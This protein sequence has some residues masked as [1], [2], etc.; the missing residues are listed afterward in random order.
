[1]EQ[2]IEKVR[3]AFGERMVF[4]GL[5]GS[6][7][8][9]EATEH[10]DIDVVVV[11]DTFT[12][13]DLTVYD[14]AISA[15]PHREKI[16]G[17]ISGVAEL[18]NWDRA[19]RFQFYY[20]TVSFYGSLDAIF[21]APDRAD[22]DH[23]VHAGA[24]AIYHGCVH[25]A[26]HEKSPEIL[27]SLYKSAVFVLQA[28]YFCE[29]EHYLRKKTDLLNVLN[30]ADRQILSSIMTDDFHQKF[31]VLSRQLMEWSGALIRTDAS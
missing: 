22:A 29:T 23:A 15:L 10:S 31:S 18:Q 16:C 19:D 12:Y 24:C 30:G 25:N 9:G 2:F 17:F 28:K 21:P 4:I 13:Q 1:M 27:R 3:A 14:H 11:L 6:H 20:D 8:R 7:A 5:Q 26:I